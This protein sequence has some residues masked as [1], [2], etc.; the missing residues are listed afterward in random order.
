MSTMH[1][2]INTIFLD[3]D[4]V[5]ADW[6]TPTLR[7]LGHSIDSVAAEWARC[8]PR[9]WDLFEVLMM[10]S[11]RAWATID[12]AGAEHW[13][14]LPIHPWAR[15]LYDACCRVAPTY[16]LTSPSRAS[17]CAAG[18]LDWIQRH[19]GRGFRDYL[20]GPA[21][22]A[23]ARPGALLIDDSPINCGKFTAAGGEAIVFPGLGN[24][25][26]ADY[27]NPM[28]RVLAQLADRTNS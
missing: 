20:I 25:H 1:A 2:P 28:P 14:N 5:L 8:N 3:V 27:R 16:L 10:P 19:F 6:Y 7:L 4:E 21:K 13:A 11:D 17:S 12:E 24:E 18:K 26:F 9:P 22:S 23:C 15:P